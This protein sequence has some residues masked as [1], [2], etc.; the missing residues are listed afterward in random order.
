M[1][2]PKVIGLAG[3]GLQVPDVG[4]AESFYSAFGLQPTKRGAG[5]GFR[6]AHAPRDEILVLPGA[7]QKRMHHLSFLMWPGDED[8]FAAKL[9]RAGLDPKTAPERPGLWFED[10]WGT[11]IN[12][13]PG[14]S[15]YEKE[16]SVERKGRVDVHGWRELDRNP[17]PQRIGHM[18]M[19][20]P[21]YEK[22]EALFNDILGLRTTDRAKGKVSFMA[23][24]EGV[25]DH[26]C[27]GLVPS[28]HRGFQ[29]ASF[30]V[31]SIDD[32]GFGIWRMRN[33]G[34]CSSSSP[35][36]LPR[37][38]RRFRGRRSIRCLPRPARAPRPIHA[39]LRP[40]AAR[41][42]RA[43]GQAPVRTL[44][45]SVTCAIRRPQPRRAS[46]LMNSLEWRIS[47][48]RRPGSAKKASP[49]QLIAVLR[50]PDSRR[51]PPPHRFRQ[52]QEPLAR[53]RLSSTRAHS[54]RR[55]GRKHHGPG[56]RASTGAGLDPSRSPSPHT[57]SR[58]VRIHEPSPDENQLM[59][60]PRE[61]PQR[62]HHIFRPDAVQ[63]TS[64]T[65]I[66]SSSFVVLQ[67]FESAYRGAIPPASQRRRGRNRLAAGHARP[68][69]R[70]RTA[71]IIAGAPQA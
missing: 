53:R 65:A 43:P 14:D 34:T 17:K 7:P 32:I 60:A 66:F 30:R 69:S 16:T 12:L 63:V 24:G 28:T 56:S 18:L 31:G 58:F 29:H 13:T 38:V 52:A 46:S 9:R 50:H 6:S 1:S 55:A 39:G 42:I 26:H 57:R 8:A 36:G 37:R 20:T 48:T 4:V 11:L 2:E 54:S 5:F 19:F 15:P 35:E 41:S 70:A 51:S 10:P 22:V 68:R 33:A 62:P 45:W 67:G 27:F 59:T 23:A 21:D 71:L 64:A 47:S 61:L 25:I 3:V 44:S 49:T 40:R